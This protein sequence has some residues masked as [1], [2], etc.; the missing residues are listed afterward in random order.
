VSSRWC[1][2][3]FLLLGMPRRM[4]R[5]FGHYGFNE[6]NPT[7]P[8]VARTALLQACVLH[9]VLFWPSVLT[10]RLTTKTTFIC[11]SIYTKKIGN[12]VCG[13][14]RQTHSCKQEGRRRQPLKV[15]TVEHVRHISIKGK[16]K[17]NRERK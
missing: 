11:V 16:H 4:T 17:M 12:T 2:V 10:Y 3:R 7:V 8:C 1:I 9:T 6:G 14:N 15:L 13:I 5:D